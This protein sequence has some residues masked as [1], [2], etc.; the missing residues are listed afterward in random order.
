MFVPGLLPSTGPVGLSNGNVIGGTGDLSVEESGVYSGAP[1]EI[2]TLWTPAALI[3]GMPEPTDID[4]IEVWGPEPGTVA[5]SDKYS[6]ESD[7]VQSPGVAPGVSVFHYIL[8]GG[9]SL[10]YISHP[11]IVGAVESLLGMAPTTAF[12]QYDQFGRNAINLD[13]LM[14]RDVD[15]VIEQF[16]PGDSI[17]FSISQMVDPLDPAGD[18]YYATGSELFH[19]EMTAAGGT[20]TTYLKHGGHEW[21]HLYTLGAM[22]ILGLPGNQRA[23]IDINAIEAIGALV[24][25]EP[26][27]L[28]LLA[29]SVLGAWMLFRR[30]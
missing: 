8:G 26:S 16:G 30:K 13:A 29:C 6:L 3:N 7:V 4:A 24:V 11:T 21:S 10:S 15:G 18:G 27:A 14:V 2:Q 9:P 12:N 17:I 25:P 5:D 23:Y 19:M 22:R 28:A 1:P 20:V